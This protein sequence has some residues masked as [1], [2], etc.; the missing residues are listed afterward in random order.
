MIPTPFRT[1]LAFSASFCACAGMFACNL[2]DRPGLNEDPPGLSDDTTGTPTGATHVNH[3]PTFGLGVH[4]LSMLEG[5]SKVLVLKARDEDGDPMKF[6]IP[7]LDSLRAL[8]PDGEKAIVVSSAGDSLK[9]AFTPGS[10][11][12]NYRFR[13]LVSDTAGGSEEQIV[14][15]SVGKVNRPPTVSFAAPATG[16]AFKVREGATLRFQA[17]A[18]D[19]DG[20]GVALL[21]L[22]NPPWPKC[23]QG[24]Y[25]AGSGK[26]TFSPSFQ[27]VTSGETTFADLVF[28]AKDDGKPSETGQIVARITVADSNSAPIW[29]TASVSLTGKEGA[30]MAFELKSLF[31]G[32]AEN[33]PVSFSAACGAVDAS[34][35]RW[36]FTPGFRDAGARECAV[37]AAD[38][39]HP[40]ASAVL[41]LVLDIAD[42]VRQV[43]VAI[44]SP[45]NGAIVNDSVV[46]VE[47]MI[48]DRKQKEQVSEKLPKE[49]PHVIIRS[50]LDSLG[51]YGAD[52]VTVIRDT[53]GPL[54][55]VISAP[56]MLNIPFPRWTW[57][58][59][60]GGDGHFRVR[61]DNPD[62]AGAMLPW[63]DTIF[64]SIL[65]LA[66][67]RHELF[68]QERDAAGNW[69]PV[70]S[71]AI[72]LDLSA[73][74]VKILSPAAGSW[75]NA[76]SVD[77]RWTVD[78]KVQ[79]SQATET[80]ASDGPI[81]ITRFVVDEAGNRGADSILIIRRSAAGAP[82]LLS[83]TPSPT[84]D[85]EWTWVPGGPGGTGTYRLGWSDGV[86]FATV[87]ATRYAAPADIAEGPQTLY[88]SESD[89]A[90]NWSTPGHLTI[91]VDRTPPKM[92]ITSP[93]PEAAVTS[94]DPA[95]GGAL[96]EAN[97][98]VTVRWSGK[99]LTAGQAQVTGPDW[100]LPALAYPAG[101][102][103]VTLTPVDAA[104][105]AGDPVSVDI[106]KRPGVA[107]VRKGSSGTGVSWQD[108]FGEIWQAAS[109][110]AGTKE[111][112]VSDGE[113]ATA[114]D[115]SASLEIPSGVSVYGGFPAVGAP[116][117]VSAR[118]VADPKSILACAGA[119]FAVRMA[120]NGS[121]LD[122]FRIDAA[123]GGLQ[124][125]SGNTGR[126][127]LISGAGGGSAVEIVAGD[128]G[129]TFL[130]E[131]VRISGAVQVLKAALTVGSKAKLQMADC[132]ITDNAA[133]DTEGGGGIWLDT[134]AKATAEGLTLSGNTVADTAGVRP[135]Q[136]R[137]EDKATA[138]VKGEVE[139][140]AAGIWVVKGG[141][142]TLNGDEVPAQDPDKGPDEGGIVIGL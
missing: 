21:A 116:L 119:G 86:W 130:L 71:A 72:T 62:P 46:A 80:L 64:L 4:D 100:T 93:G 9:I 35:L 73:P 103:T 135:L 58:G 12:G 28:R 15:I 104:G 16:T 102:V 87:K 124:G 67:G 13:I 68:V 129:K 40:P 117:D 141:K 25:D 42:S 48:G 82:P 121:V 63:T 139:G 97:G 90:G 50:Y 134:N 56:A 140:D 111:V 65:P 18:S 114:K 91:V 7:N 20:D 11:K 137:V 52:S 105:N 44:L 38:S 131:H 132:A 128:N 133:S 36:T 89:S 60:G 45:V 19:P 107:F 95:L 110:A 88:V 120:G 10:A 118:A 29:K 76:S 94:A 136:M 53:Q 69:S 49:G 79:T 66:E 138:T 32:D 98:P 126:N 99:G 37:T 57:H 14:T 106:H 81:R 51:N 127:L 23:G 77:V 109:A 24:S 115:G 22:A 6:A 74:V 39:H 142:A 33:D 55:P 31:T 59:G 108:A 122:G 34:S 75:T 123:G 41:N 27:C 112:W 70:A 84:R 43:D 1:V 2:T 92:E 3:A 83:G 96:T 26:V 54:P 17:V 30:A 61:L 5:E 85:P 78:G 47:W 8:F 101:D 113:Y 125:D